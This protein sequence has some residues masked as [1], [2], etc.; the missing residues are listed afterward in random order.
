[1][2]FLGRGPVRIGAPPRSGVGDLS[3]FIN[4]NPARL[5]ISDLDGLHE[6]RGVVTSVVIRIGTMLQKIPDHQV[7]SVGNGCRQWGKAVVITFVDVRTAFNEQGG[8]G[9]VS[10]QRGFMQRRAV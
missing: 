7:V 3:A 10:T 4:E 2:C 8:Y 9:D 1:M 5:Q 6:C